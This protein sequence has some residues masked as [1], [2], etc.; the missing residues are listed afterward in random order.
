LNYDTVLPDTQLELMKAQ[1][2]AYLEN[3]EFFDRLWAESLQTPM[4][5]LERFRAWCETC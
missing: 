2:K 1:Q 3:K 4:E 5:A